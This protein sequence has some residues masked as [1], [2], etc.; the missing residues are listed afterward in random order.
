LLLRAA[1]MGMKLGGVA[2]AVKPPAASCGLTPAGPIAA[3]RSRPDRGTTMRT[4]WISSLARRCGARC[5]VSWG[6]RL[7][8]ATDSPEAVLCRALRRRTQRIHPVT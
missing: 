6:H 3:A 4:P 1:S 7:R 2:N 8:P 5:E